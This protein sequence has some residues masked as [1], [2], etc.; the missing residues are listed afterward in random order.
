MNK[1]L[2]SVVRKRV[3][4]IH[5]MS[6]DFKLEV[7]NKPNLNSMAFYFPLKLATICI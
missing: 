2:T 6:I 4:T 7:H 3:R 5:F 1:S